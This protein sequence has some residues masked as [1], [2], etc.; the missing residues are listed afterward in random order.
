MDETCSQYTGQ[1]D[2]TS[3]DA[4]LKTAQGRPMPLRG[5]ER[6]PIVGR[7]LSVSPEGAADRF[8]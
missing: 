8:A 7:N 5:I 3:L 6:A 2:T 1:L 4:R